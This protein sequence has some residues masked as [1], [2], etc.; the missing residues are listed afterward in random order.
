MKRELR[1]LSVTLS[2]LFRLMFNLYHVLSFI[3]ARG[4]ICIWVG[5]DL[6]I[7]PHK[8]YVYTFYPEALHFR[9]CLPQKFKLMI[10]IFLHARLQ[11]SIGSWYLVRS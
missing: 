4:K 6:R 7:T 2:P 8:K 10:R 11:L 1:K 5:V 3:G 9:A